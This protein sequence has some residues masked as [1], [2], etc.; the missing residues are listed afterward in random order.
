MQHITHDDNHR[1]RTSYRQGHERFSRLFVLK[2]WL[3]SWCKD[4]KL[5]FVNNLN[6]FWERPRLF[7][8]V[9]LH[10]SRV[11]AELVSDNIS[12]M[13][14]VS[15]FSKRCY[16]DFCSTHLNYRGTCSVQ[17]MQTVSVPRIVR[18][19]YKFYAG[20]RKNLIV[21]KPEK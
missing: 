2:E 9:G 17:S 18:S 19:K 1:V 3:L 8:A 21:I 11:G 16:N 7:C 15:Q 4:Q 13:L 5:L 10:P 12:R 20:S 14:L 6:L